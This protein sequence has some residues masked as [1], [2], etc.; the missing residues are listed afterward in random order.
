MASIAYIKDRK[1]WRV[2]WRA[3]NRKTHRV[4]AGSRVF[5]EKH[6]AVAYYAEME[7][8]EK[9]W[10]TG[11][12]DTLDAIGDIAAE[13]RNYCKRHTSRTQE[14]YARV[15]A[16]FLEALPRTVIRIQQ[17]DHKHIEEYLYQLRDAGRIPR[18]RNAHLTV[19][20]AFCRYYAR[21]YGLPNPAARVSMLTEDPPEARWITDEDYER[22]VAA[23]SPLARDRIIFLAHTGL[24]ATEFCDL[25][26]RGGLDPKSQ[27]ITI[28]G[29]GR[30]R[31]T[32]PLNKPCREVLSRPHI[33]RPTT[34]N[35]LGQQLRRVAKRAGVRSMG[36]HALRHYFATKLLLKG[37]PLIKVSKLLGHR[38][39]RTTERVYA[40][41]LDADLRDATKILE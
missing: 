7:A 20:K 32:V 22:L 16:A 35:P 17:L 19:I 12:V 4:F 41:I 13:F 23:A 26:R 33:Y 27:T 24:R 8:Q 11:Q 40:H 2:R 6:L 25:T 5:M 37:L 18:T 15:M 21:Q 36:P 28:T 38:S 34:R 3:T 1:R 10:R 29:K 31:R 39:V 9:L 30:K 14:H